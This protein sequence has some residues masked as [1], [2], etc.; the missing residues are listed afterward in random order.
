MMV[1]SAAVG[2][3][4]D[5]RL[6]MSTA[7]ESAGADC[8]HDPGRRCR[9]SPDL[10]HEGSVRLRSSSSPFHRRMAWL[11]ASRRAGPASDLSGAATDL[12]LDSAS[13]FQQF[14]ALSVEILHPLSRWAVRPSLVQW[15]RRLTAWHDE[16]R[17]HYL[18]LLAGLI[19][20][21]RAYLDQAE[22]TARL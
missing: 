18:H 22:I 20:C 9:R 1:S 3:S 8:Y 5:E 16:I 14:D 15:C 11:A 4:V 6:R 17:Y 13:C 19:Q 7:E 21:N 2:L 10:F 12:L